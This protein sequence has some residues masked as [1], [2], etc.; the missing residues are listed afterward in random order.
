M[1]QCTSC[2]CVCVNDLFQASV[3]KCWLFTRIHGHLSLW[4]LQEYMDTFLHGVYKDTWT[5]FSMVFTRIHGHLSL[6]CLQEYMDT[7][8]HGVYKDTRTPFSMVFTRI[9]GHLSPW[10]LQGYMDTFLHGVYKDI[11]T[12]FFVALNCL[13]INALCI[14]WQAGVKSGA[15]V[16]CSGSFIL[17]GESCWT[18]WHKMAPAFFTPNI[19]AR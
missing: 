8:L 15:F 3:W 14:V 6:W 4:C 5:P 13:I 16:V 2:F 19:N 12:S 1:W 17:S 10:C 7:F 9:H 11:W 18:C